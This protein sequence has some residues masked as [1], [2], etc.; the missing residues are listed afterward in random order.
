MQN[1]RLKALGLQDP[2]QLTQRLERETRDKIERETRARIEQETRATIERETRDKIER[3]TRAMIE[4]ETTSLSL[5]REAY[6]RNN[7]EA[8]FRTTRDIKCESSAQAIRVAEKR[9]HDKALQTRMEVLNE[10]PDICLDGSN[11]NR[12]SSICSNSNRNRNS[13]RNSSICSNNITLTLEEV[14]KLSEKE[15][16]EIAFSN[17]MIEQPRKKKNLRFANDLDCICFFDKNEPPTRISIDEDLEYVIALSIIEEGNTRR[18]DEPLDL[19]IAFSL[20]DM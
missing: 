11:S 2:Y 14:S 10:N 19:A 6:E 13:N 17:S 12:N 9:A 8:L 7:L 20:Q 4:R 3:E 16:L 18:T 1:N 5:E 15:M